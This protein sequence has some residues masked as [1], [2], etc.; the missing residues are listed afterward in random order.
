MDDSCAIQLG[1]TASELAGYAAAVLNGVAYQFH[2]I[3]LHSYIHF[4]LQSTLAS[5]V[6]RH[7]IRLM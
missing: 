4:L 1:T 6:I 3:L 7:V 5:D 2:H